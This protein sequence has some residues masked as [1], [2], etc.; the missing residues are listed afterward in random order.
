MLEKYDLNKMF[1]EIKEDEEMGVSKKEK[2][3][4]DKIKEM[5]FEKLKEK[6]GR[7]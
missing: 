4:Q 2:I 6:K 7:K 1:E 5:M 3:S